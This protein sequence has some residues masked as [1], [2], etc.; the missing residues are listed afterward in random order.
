MSLLYYGVLWTSKQQPALNINNNIIIIINKNNNIIIIFFLLF[1]YYDILDYQ[2]NE[3]YNK[4]VTH[5][6]HMYMV[7]DFKIFW[8]TQSQITHCSIEKS[9]DPTIC[10]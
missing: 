1:F 5:E 8:S 6:F 9:R 10:H 2:Q 7:K 3:V 4:D